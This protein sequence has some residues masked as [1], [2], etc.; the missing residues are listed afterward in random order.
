MAFLT[1]D[2]GGAN[3]TVEVDSSD[4]SADYDDAGTSI[5]PAY[6][7]KPI[8]S[9]TYAPR[10]VW[11]FTTGPLTIDQ[12]S[13]LIAAAQYPLAINVTGDAF[14]TA[15]AGGAPTI[16]AIVRVGRRRYIPIGATGGFYYGASLTITKAD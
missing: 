6:S 10:D 11:S 4:A 2:T 8:V 9:Q 7:G 14:R 5:E 15:S 12:H 1:I 13:A 16:S 3:L